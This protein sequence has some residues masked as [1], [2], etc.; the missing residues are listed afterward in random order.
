MNNIRVI[1]KKVGDP[2]YMT[3]IPNELKKLQ[4]IVEGNIETVTITKD[5]CIICNEE[6]KLKRLSHNCNLFGNDFVGTIIFVGINED[7]FDNI[8]FSYGKFRDLF[9]ELYGD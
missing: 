6:G 1:I 8:P 7:E 2:P 9:P 5:C 3:V 4:E